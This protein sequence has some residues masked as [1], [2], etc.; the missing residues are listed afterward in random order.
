M[1]R[2]VVALRAE[3]RPL[4]ERYRLDADSDGP[5]RTYRGGGRCLVIS[6]VGKEAAA[7]ATAHLDD[8][9]FGIW[10][11][12]G[13]AGHRDRAPGD[14]VRAS[15]ITDGASGERF[16]PSLLGLGHIESSGV[17][18]VETPEGEFSSSDVYDMEAS[19]FFVTAVRASTADLVQAVKIVSDNRDTGTGALSG[20][21][22]SALIRDNLDAID[23]VVTHLEALGDRLGPIRSAPDTS[24]F[25]GKWRFT[26]SQER[27]LKRL[28]VRA[29]ALGATAATDGFGETATATEILSE[30]TAR[31]SR[32]ALEQTEL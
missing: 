30:L 31:V 20:P 28:L 6:G 8:G 32:A 29:R 22:V 21:K 5:F 18:T 19:A 17:T 4:I 25:T 12:V 9:P 13:I 2:F 24:P 3:A 10:L 7:A 1:T 16:Y 26:T 15:R 11:N 23:A 14:L 27:E